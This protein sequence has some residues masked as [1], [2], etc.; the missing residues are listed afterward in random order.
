MPQSPD[1]LHGHQVSRP[2]AAVPQRIKCSNPRA[3][4]RPSVGR[5]EPFRQPRHGFMPRDHVLPVPAIP[6][7]PVNLLVFAG[8]KFPPPPTL[9]HNPIP[10]LPPSP[11]P[12]TSPPPPHP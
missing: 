7:H 8:A 11:P 9:P 4:Q 1:T 10:P 12:L 3:Q 5:L 2:R 6:R